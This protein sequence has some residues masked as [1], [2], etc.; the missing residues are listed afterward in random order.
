MC[1]MDSCRAFRAS[2][3]DVSVFGAKAAFYYLGFWLRKGE[4]LDADAHR[5]WCPKR[6]VVRE[7]AATA[8]F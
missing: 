5:A 3:I 8:D 1:I 7:Y 2:H 4:F 6:K